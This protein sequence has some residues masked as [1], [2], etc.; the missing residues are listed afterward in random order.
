VFNVTIA[1]GAGLSSK[2]IG[3]VSCPS[4]IGGVYTITPTGGVA[5]LTTPAA[6][7]PTLTAVTYNVSGVAVTQG[8]LKGVTAGEAVTGNSAKVKI[9]LPTHTG[10]EVYKIVSSGVGNIT[11]K[12]DTTG[13]SLGIASTSDYTAGLLYTNAASTALAALEVNLNSAVSGTQT[14]TVT[15]VDANTGV[16]TALYSAS[17]KWGAAPTYTKSTAFIN[18]TLGSASVADVTTKSSTGTYNGT[19]KARID[20]RQ[21]TSTDTATAVVTG[22]GNVKTVIVSISGAGSVDSASGGAARGT[23]ATVAASLTANG[24]DDFYV[25]ADGRTGDASIVV[26]VDGVSVASWTWTFLGDAKSL[27][28]DAVNSPTKIYLGVGETG[29]VSVLAYDSNAKLATLPASLTVTSDT[30]TIASAV[31]AANGL[32]TVTG[33]AAGKTKINFSDGA[34]ATSLNKVAIQVIVTKTTA[35]TGTVKLA[36]DKASYAPGEKMTLTVTAL[37]VDGSPVADGSRNLFSSTGVTANVSL[38]GLPTTAVVL[39]GGKAEYTLYAPFA[40]GDVVLTGSEGAGVVDTV[41]VAAATAAGTAYVAPKTSVT[42]SVVN[43][44][45]DASTDAAN[46]A[47]DAANAATDA[48]LAA[49]DAADAATAAAEDASA[50]VAKLAKSVNTA[51]KALKKQIT[52]LTALVNKL[53]KK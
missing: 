43:P 41:G 3:T 48:A 36:F 35:K 17:V 18:T 26:T 7:T 42:V 19:A 44:S 45:Q 31:A 4:L 50:A 40:S 13:S 32:A 38:T 37:D 20:V 25:F 27:K 49:A 24:D 2:V 8:T 39:A 15:A 52:S 23:S 47:T 11:G 29:T 1:A 46:E 10:S 5:D 53:L 21:Y 14:I 22:S 6:I 30:A 16:N 33:V 9:F 34:L 28:E 12:T 51:L